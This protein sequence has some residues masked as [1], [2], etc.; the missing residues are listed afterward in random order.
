MKTI[1]TA[2]DANATFGTGSEVGRVIQTVLKPPETHEQRLVRTERDHFDRAT[3]VDAVNYEG[4]V[5]WPYRGPQDGFF[6]SVED[7]RN[8]CSSSEE[9]LPK[10]VWACT[11][12]IFRLNADQILDDATQDHHDDARGEISASEEVRLQ[13]FLDEWSAAQNIVSW[14]EDRSRAVMLKVSPNE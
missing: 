8:Y 9:D 11:K 1:E 10:F 4:W 12:E 3:K 14:H 7:L 6:H 2:E 13:A 5:F